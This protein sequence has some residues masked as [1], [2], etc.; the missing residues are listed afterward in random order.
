[1]VERKGVFDPLAPGAASAPATDAPAGDWISIVPVPADAPPPSLNHAKLGKPELV[2][3]YRDALGRPIGFVRRFK[4]YDG[5]KE[6]LPLT[7]CRNPE[8][9][10]R[11]WRTKSWPS[12]SRPLY[13]LD[14]LAA[15]PEAPV[16]VCEGER[17]TDAAGR[18][19]REF[20]AVTSPAG[21]KSGA[22]ADWTPLRQR[23]VVIWP[24]ADAAGADYAATAARCLDK[25]SVAARIIAPPAGVAEGWDA[26]DAELQG[27]TGERVRGLIAGAQILPGNDGGGR[28]GKS[29]KKPGEDGLLELVDA[30]VELWH[31]E[32]REAFVSYQIDREIWANA[33]VDDREFHIW[34]AGRYYAANGSAVS[35]QTFD[36]AMNVIAARAVHDGPEFKTFRRI[37]EIG[38]EKYAEKIYIDR[39]D[40]EWKA[41]EIDA[42][43]WHIIDRPPIKFLR[44]PGQ[45]ALPMPVK[46]DAGIGELQQYVHFENDDDF[47]MYV[48]FIIAAHYPRGPYPVLAISGVDGSAKTTLSNLT[49]ALIDP[50]SAPLRNI[51]RDERDL[52]IAAN[53]NHVIAL[54]N[55]SKFRSWFADSLCRLASG[56]GF[57]TRAL[58]T[59]QSEIIIQACCPIIINGIGD[60]INR[61]DLQARSIFLS[62]P[63]MPKGMRRSE[64]VFWSSFNA[65]APRIYGAILDAVSAG[66][67]N[68]PT[69]KIDGELPRMADFAVWI[70]ACTSGLGWEKGEFLAIY[71][72]NRLGTVLVTLQSS[73][74]GQTLRKFIDEL[75]HPEIGWEGTASELLEKLE[76]V[77]TES[78]RRQRAWPKNPGT[79]GMELR[80]ISNVLS[81]IGIEI[82]HKRDGKT[83]DRLMHIYRASP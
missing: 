49:R 5:S 82:D 52:L 76:M 19:L 40:R 33:R 65:A 56:S 14:R 63:K 47:K 83:R 68:L 24:D 43:G 51:P 46:D 13:G 18:L 31:N 61:A 26:A 32:N 27:W 42:Q 64:A 34:L 22:K 57:S 7:F 10:V 80:R 72:A 71:E 58:H 38:G 1:M 16:V 2:H 41:F 66:L 44:S 48:A 3:E 59:D 79:L 70:E 62:L 50:S 17:A 30:D 75:P 23:D 9:G 21:A 60:L 39:G 8:T 69:I 81:Q 28:S 54:D 15:R 37:G 36:A 6:F 73:T 29:K 55:I 77:A 78:N 12:P 74:V 53:N 25:I 11:S 45:K 4:K 35:D 67:R 20:V